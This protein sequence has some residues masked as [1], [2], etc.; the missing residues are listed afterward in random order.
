MLKLVDPEGLYNDLILPET[1]SGK[2]HARDLGD[3]HQVI[4]TLPE[5]YSETD[6]PIYNGENQTPAVTVSTGTGAD[7][8][9]WKKNTDYTL[10]WKNWN[11]DVY[12]CVD[13]SWGYHVIVKPADASENGNFTGSAEKEFCIRQRPINV[14]VEHISKVYDGTTD[15]PEDFQ[16]RM[17]K[18]SILTGDNGLV[19]WEYQKNTSPIL[20][21]RFESA[22]V[23]EK[24]IHFSGEYHLTGER[25]GN[26]TFYGVKG[27]INP[28]DI[29][30]TSVV[31]NGTLTYNGA[32]Q[33]P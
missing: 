15:A 27:T 1:Y 16:V 22:M 26:Y 33:T 30:N 9:V 3:S 17:D 6:G 18:N 7:Q 28:A 31:Q 20:R 8:I 5:G 21:S 12:E 19:V 25:S 10:E 2:I 4:A 32:P 23:G 13:A 29:T 11:D 24:L 14:N